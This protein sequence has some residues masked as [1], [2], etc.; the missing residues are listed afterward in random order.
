MNFRTMT[1]GDLKLL[2]DWAAR[3]GWNP[4][5]EDAEAFHRAD[6]D[7]FFAAEVDGRTVAGI[8]VVNHSD[9]FAFLGLYLCLPEYRGKGIGFGLWSHA[10]DHA[11]GRTIGLDGVPDQQDNYR[12]SGFVAVGETYRFSGHLA[13]SLSDDVREVS[14]RDLQQAVDIVQAANGYDS[15]AY[16]T[17]WLSGTETRRTYM[18]E[19]GRAVATVRQCREGQKIGPLVAG[20]PSDAIRLLKDLASRRPARPMIIDVP[21]RQADLLAFL[22]EAGFECGFNTA[23]MYRGAAPESSD[24]L[25]AVT[26]L[27]LG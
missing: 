4:G 24:A 20:T 15:P 22:Q 19:G 21:G 12:K 6:P 2:L 18:L 25:R 5:L 13:G 11:G 3:E 27:E 17:A 1:K 26:T 23:R 14:E 9:R 7:G 16:L 8:S 10:M